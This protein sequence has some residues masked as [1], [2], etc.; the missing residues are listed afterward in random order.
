MDIN[1]YLHCFNFYEPYIRPIR[2]PTQGDIITPYKGILSSTEDKLVG[3][4]IIGIIVITNK[5]DIEQK[6]AKYISYNPV[7]K[8]NKIQ[9]ATS[10]DKKKKLEKNN[11]SEP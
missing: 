9:D 7:Y 1:E 3:K 11:Y 2:N 8:A 10:S 4:E 6:K 5:C